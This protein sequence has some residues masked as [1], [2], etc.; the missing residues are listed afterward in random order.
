M[1]DEPREL[2]DRALLPLKPPE[3]PPKALELRE[4]RPELRLAPAPPL[5]LLA[6]APAPPLRL[7][8]PAPPPPPL[9]RAP[10]PPPRLPALRLL[11][12]AV[13]PRLPEPRDSP[14]AV[15]PYLPAVALLE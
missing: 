7:P 3:P 5:R 13:P 8:A 2:L 1:L 4:A 9:A 12:L 11:A 15:P 14:R 10:A 6:L